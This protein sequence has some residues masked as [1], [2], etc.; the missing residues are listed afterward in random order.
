MAAPRVV[1]KA[2]PRVHLSR[3]RQIAPHSDFS[4]EPTVSIETL[5]APNGL[6]VGREPDG[7]AAASLEHIQRG[8]S[9]QLMCW[10]GIP[11][12]GSWKDLL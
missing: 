2:P 12:A 6:S 5:G 7:K 9:S 11:K 4:S 8:V 10:D 1:V 3:W